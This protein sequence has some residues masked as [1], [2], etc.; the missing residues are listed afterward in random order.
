MTK[1]EKIVLKALVILLGYVVG[2]TWKAAANRL[3]EDIR[4]E[5]QHPV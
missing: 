5:L 3:I 1:F 4:Q 2:V